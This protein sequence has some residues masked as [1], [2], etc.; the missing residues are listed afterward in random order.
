MPSTTEPVASVRGVTHHYGSTLALD[1]IT[2]DIPPGRMVGLIGP[3]G[4]GKSSL[5]GLIGGAKKIQKGKV[6][7]LG[8]D[9]AD[10]RHRGAVCPRIAY[11]PQGLGKNLYFELSVFENIDF[12]A[13]LFGMARAER[14]R[15]IGDL[16][17]ATGLGPFPDRPAGKLSGGMK[18]KVGLCGA[19]IHDP[20]LLILDEPTTGVDPLSRQQFWALIDEIRSGRPEMSVLISTAYMDEAQRWDWIVAMDAGRVLATGTPGELMERTGTRDLEEA[21]VALL[22]PE[23]RGDRQKLTIPPRPEIGGEPAITATRLTRRFGNF[24]AVNDV[25]L[26]IER[27]EI[28]GFLGSNGCGKSTTMKML[29]GLLPAS[30][31]EATLFGQPIDANSNETRMRVGY[32]TQAFSLYGELTVRQNLDLHARLYN[33]PAEQARE[34]IRELVDRFG[35]ESHLDA[36]A[37]Q[38]PLGLKQRLSLAVAVLHGPDML[39]LDEPTSGVDPVARDEFWE[40]LIDLSRR[41]GVTIFVST[42][43]MNEALR[44]DRISLMHAGNVLACDTPQALMKARGTDD[45][46]QAFIAYIADA[47]GEAGQL[48]RSKEVGVEPGRQIEVPTPAAALAVPLISSFSLGRMLAY[49]N[50]EAMEILRD[51]VRLA[52]AFVGSAI[53]MFVFGFGITTDVEDIKYA[54]LDL[55]QTPESRSYLEAF[56]GSRYFL[57][58]PPLYTADQMKRRLE[59]NDISLA[60]EIPPLFGRDVRRGGRPEVS[61]LVDGANPLRAETIKQ[62]VAGVHGT[63]LRDPAQ[64]IGGTHSGT[65]SADIQVRYLYNPS[66]ESIYAI[67]PSVPAI[68]L[69]LI[70]AILMAVSVVREKELGSITNFYVTPTTRLEFLLG[71]QL[72]YIVI[73]MINYV[74]LMLMSIFVFGVPVKGSALTLTLC[75]FLYVTV[76][77]GIGLLISTFTSSQVAAV[78]ITAIVTILPTTQFS[79]LL[80]PVST[81]E[82]G[83]RRM[84]SLWPTTYYMHASVGA[85]TKG[86]PARLLAEDAIILACFIPVLMVLASLALRSQEE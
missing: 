38:L 35:L 37:E 43:F 81:L 7:V 30:E 32:M 41:Q 74:I 24:T 20:D 34:R 14:K 80:Q 1:D 17:E 64:D 53:M 52:F 59:A 60:I 61:A 65:N 47:A 23:K 77:T 15:R 62:Y 42:H 21:F 67:V 70:P 5:M 12:F 63:F 50:R 75:A 71:K 16:L 83:A 76:T 28:F 3:D 6:I 69:V 51:P 33:L 66:F 19:L 56:A 79:G 39:I 36:L 55:D 58:R 54:S 49:T 68:V 72:P 45:L 18:Q 85:F 22:P 4:V 82:G 26:S 40:L 84:G 11:M 57:Q 10:V 9:I 46:E 27:G 78:F 13:R 2:I 29:T 31:G 8:G 25:N 86:L 73:G 44:C 48:A